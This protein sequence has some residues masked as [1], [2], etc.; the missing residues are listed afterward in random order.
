MSRTGVRLGFH[1][2]D[3]SQR[4]KLWG[5]R[6]IQRF[7]FPSCLIQAAPDRA[8]WWIG[9]CDCLEL[10]ASC[11]PGHRRMGPAICIRL[12]HCQLL[13]LCGWRQAAPK[14]ETAIAGP[15]RCS[16]IG[17]GV[18]GRVLG[19]V[20]SR[21][22]A[23]LVA[24]PLSFCKRCS[25]LQPTKRGWVPG[26]P[27]R[28]FPGS[29][30]PRGVIEAPHACVLSTALPLD[31]KS[32][33]GHAAGRGDGPWD[34]QSAYNHRQEMMADGGGSGWVREAGGLAGH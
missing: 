9:F 32:P 6:L 18:F 33:R 12:S 34:A 30:G 20:W 22:T 11:A 26:F 1:G 23:R 10:E 15:G 29:S 5:Y 31:P 4:P 17:W 8:P 24:S 2:T 16:E 28:N 21:W 19:P 27:R 14:R 13:R 25:L 7:Q 3:G